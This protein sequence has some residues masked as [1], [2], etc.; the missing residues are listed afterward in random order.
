[1]YQK[2]DHVTYQNFKTERGIVKRDQEPGEET[3]FV[4]FVEDGGGNLISPKV[5]HYDQYTAARTATK[6]LTKGWT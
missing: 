6:Y 3:V 5:D 4:V 2:G 1:M